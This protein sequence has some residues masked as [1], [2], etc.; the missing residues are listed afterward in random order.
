MTVFLLMILLNGVPVYQDPRPYMS[1]RECRDEGWRI[2]RDYQR[3]HIKADFSCE[4]EYR[5]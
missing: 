4:E 1:M 3:D 5:S 2:V